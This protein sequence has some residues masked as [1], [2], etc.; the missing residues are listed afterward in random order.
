MDEDVKLKRIFKELM[1]YE[2]TSRR[3]NI[4]WQSKRL[5]GM[6]RDNYVGNRRVQ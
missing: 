5:R 1:K 6:A 2:K 4:N 3:V